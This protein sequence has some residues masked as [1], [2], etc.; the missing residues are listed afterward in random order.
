[1]QLAAASIADVVVVEEEVVLLEFFLFI[2]P[3]FTRPQVSQ[4]GENMIIYK[5]YWP[6]R[7]S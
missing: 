6:E 1:M 4:E 2:L 5:L 3:K 7:R